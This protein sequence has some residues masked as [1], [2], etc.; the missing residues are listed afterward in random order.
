MTAPD[1]FA[2]DAT[3]AD[4]GEFG[5]IALIRERLGS[6]QSL[7]LGPGDDEERMEAKRR[8][9]ENSPGTYIGEILAARDSS[10]TRW[11]DRPDRPLTVWIQ[12]KTHVADFA[13]TYADRVR[14]A[15]HIPI[16]VFEIDHAG[17]VPAPGSEG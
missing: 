5:L 15:F 3:L 8:L 14:D 13:Q 6:P 11:P 2:Q 1:S 7:L 9:R 17:R 4:V 16:T 12:R 10:L